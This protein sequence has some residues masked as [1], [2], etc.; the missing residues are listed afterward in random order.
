[1][2]TKPFQQIELDEV[3]STNAEALR[4]AA[5]GERGPLWIT[6]ARQTQGR[7]RSGRAWTSLPGNLAA[8][9]LIAPGCTPAELH[10]LSLVTGVAVHNAVAPLHDL[11]PVVDAPPPRLKWPNDILAG[12]AKLG[13]ILIESTIADGQPVAAIGIGLNLTSAPPLDGRATAARA[14]GRMSLSPADLLTAIDVSL[15]H[16]LGVWQK[17]TGFPAIRRAWLSRAHAIGTPL[18]INNG[19]DTISGAFAGIDETGALLLGN[20]ST[21]PTEIRRF[22]YGDV[23][24]RPPRVTRTD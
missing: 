2:W 22:T 23:S 20:V 3:D 19:A 14:D 18:S 11:S 12:D 17:G 7:G 6:A 10:E 5:T 13:G 1:M 21:N 9:L 24:L 8:T 16:W 15:R 4:R